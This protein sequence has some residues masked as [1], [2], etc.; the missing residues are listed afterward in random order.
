M[1]VNRA[2]AKNEEND[3]LRLL[4]TTLA[5]TSAAVL[6]VILRYVKRLCYDASFGWDD[7]AIGGALAC[8]AATSAFVILAI[9]NGYGKHI[10]DLNDE[11]ARTA[12]MWFFAAQSAYKVTVGLNKIS[13]LVLYHRIFTDPN[14]QKLVKAAGVFVFAWTATALLLT[15]LQ[16]VPLSASWNKNVH[17]RCINKSAFWIAYAILNIL[18]DV[19]VLGIPI[20][21]IRRLQLP[22]GK[23]CQVYF[24]F[25]LG[26]L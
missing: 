20:P 23:R 2:L 19:A 11:Q 7:A 12:L 3:G 6:F 17:G 10:D 22:L 13:Q 25:L 1:F 15:V 26:G 16:C 24:L 21:Q 9:L 8:S 4:I 14:F 5:M 18:T